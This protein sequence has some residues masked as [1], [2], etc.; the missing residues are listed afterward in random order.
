MKPYSINQ[1][2]CRT[3]ANTI[4]DV[5]QAKKKNKLINL[6]KLYVI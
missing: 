2:V 5:W 6:I 1:N 3:K 4:L